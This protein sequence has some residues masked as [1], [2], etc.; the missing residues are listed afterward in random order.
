MICGKSPELETKNMKAPKLGRDRHSLGSMWNHNTLSPGNDK[1]WRD[2]KGK[3]A[4]KSD[5]ELTI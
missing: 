1:I 4:S 2:V 3:K 5:E